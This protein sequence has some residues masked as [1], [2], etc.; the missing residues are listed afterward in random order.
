MAHMLKQQ[1]QQKQLQAQLQVQI[2]QLRQA[3]ASGALSM[4]SD[5]TAPAD[6]PNEATLQLAG[7]TDEWAEEVLLM[8][9]ISGRRPARASAGAPYSGSLRVVAVHSGGGMGKTTAASTYVAA[10]REGEYPGGA[11]WL[12]G[13]E[14]V[15]HVAKKRAHAEVVELAV[16]QEEVV[17]VVGTQ[18]HV[19]AEQTSVA[20]EGHEVSLAEGVAEHAG[21]AGHAVFVCLPPNLWWTTC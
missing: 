8:K 13:E 19:V 11:V 21:F 14:A 9:E 1:A 17:E 5:R 6:G 10:T 16:E 20:Q 2:D 18:V 12:C 7:G 4:P 15:G 3:S